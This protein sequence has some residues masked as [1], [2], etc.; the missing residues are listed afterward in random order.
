MSKKANKPKMTRDLACKLS[1]EEGQAK[2]K[3]LASATLERAQLEQ[4]AKDAAA[5]FRTKLKPVKKRIAELAEMI[6]SG[7]EERPVEVEMVESIVN[8]AAEWKRLDTGECFTEPL[9]DDGQAVIPG[10]RQSKKKKPEAADTKPKGPS[11]DFSTGEPAIG[12]GPHDEEIELSAEQAD[13]VRNGRTVKVQSPR[14]REVEILKLKKPKRAKA[15]GAA[16][17]GE[18]LQ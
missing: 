11:G 6:S 1:P 7:I 14:G 5:S 12:M 13:D 9:E 10:A 2:S 15:N 17:V 16:E 8:G 18:T 3:E 4:D